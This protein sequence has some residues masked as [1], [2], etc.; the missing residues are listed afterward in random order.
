VETYQRLTHEGLGKVTS[1]LAANQ[2]WGILRV[3][4]G[5]AWKE[6]D[7]AS[8]G[9]KVT[10]LGDRRAPLLGQILARRCSIPPARLDE[11]VATQP[12]TRQRI[13]EMCVRAHLCTEE[14]LQKA[15]REQILSELADLWLWSGARFYFEVGQQRSRNA[16]FDARR[17]DEQ[18]TPVSW[19]GPLGQLLT[20]AKKAFQ[21]FENLRKEVGSGESVFAFT[22]AARA[23]LYEQGGFQRLVDAD[24]RVVVLLD[25]KRSISEIVAKV[26]YGMVE[27]LRIVAKLK[28]A[29][30]ITKV[31]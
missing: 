12:E 17:R 19:S 3:K 9:L 7:F 5:Q 29:G 31:R 11:L 25:G 24:Q 30:A 20:D 14:D 28:K 27:T 4:D 2:Y 21:D 6:Y 23:K 8:G 10:S 18:V 22:P 13:G 15:I 1:D 26:P 16:E